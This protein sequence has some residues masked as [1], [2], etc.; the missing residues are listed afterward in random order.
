MGGDGN[1]RIN[2]GAGNDLITGGS[3]DD[4]FVVGV[5]ANTR[6][7]ITDFATKGTADKIDLSAFG[8]TK[9][10]DIKMFDVIP[11]GSQSGPQV[12]II[13]PND[14][15]LILQNLRVSDL[16]ADDFVGVVGNDGV[17]NGTTGNL[18]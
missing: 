1:D 7:I 12:H 18:P 2:A 3:G 5:Q 15:V 13:L 16:S 6:D 17:V 8:Y 4:V 14:Q 10:S 11:R 9:L